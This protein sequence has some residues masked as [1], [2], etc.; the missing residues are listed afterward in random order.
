MVFTTNTTHILHSN[1]DG[2]SFT[3]C[4]TAPEPKNEAEELDRRASLFKS[5]MKQLHT[6]C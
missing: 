6:Y 5:P 2:D 4:P 3:E 1:T